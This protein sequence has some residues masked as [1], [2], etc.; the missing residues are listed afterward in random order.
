[1][2]GEVRMPIQRK[3][4]AWARGN[5]KENPECPREG[6]TTCGRRTPTAF[7]R[8]A[9]PA[10]RSFEQ[11]LLVPKLLLRHALVCEAL[12]PQARSEESG[13][14]TGSARWEAELPR[15]R[16]AEAGASAREVGRRGDFLSFPNSVWERHC[17]RNSV[18]RSASARHSPPP[19]NGVS[20]AS[21]FPNGVWER[22]E[23]SRALFY[24]A[25]A[26]PEPRVVSSEHSLFWLG[27]RGAQPLRYARITD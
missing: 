21:A 1:M 4:G 7:G 14:H 9:T 19:R 25:Q 3:A 2:G 11:D 20:P 10:R 23:K 6:E 18:A 24:E 22:G 8:A 26:Q 16:R 13:R 27:L 17:P 15:Q 5:A 12:L